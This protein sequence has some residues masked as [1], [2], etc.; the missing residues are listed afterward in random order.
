MSARLLRGLVG[1]WLLFVTSP[2]LAPSPSGGGAPPVFGALGAQERPVA[3]AD[4]TV[5]RNR[6]LAPLEISPGGAFRRAVA[7]PGW[8]HAAIGAHGRGGFYFGVQAAIVYTLL[9][10]RARIGETQDRV[11]RRESVLLSRLTPEARG[12]FGAVQAAFDGDPT[13]AELRGL[14]ES[15]ARQQE[16]MVALG[17]FFVLIS[18]VDAFVSAHL[19]RFP[20]PLELETRPG[21]TEGSVDIG[22]RLPLPR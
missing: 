3:P 17:V 22:F 12:D 11:R 5:R 14:L 15:R 2:G 6:D 7:F 13:L 18:G 9:R 21:P 10:A 8:G 4:S 16:D 20:E 19:S 1:A